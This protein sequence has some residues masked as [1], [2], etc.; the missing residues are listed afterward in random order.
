MLI[1]SALVFLFI[2]SETNLFDEHNDDCKDLDLCLILDKAHFEKNI[3]TNQVL[4]VSPDFIPLSS[5]KISQFSLTFSQTEFAIIS[6]IIPIPHNT[7][8]KN[9]SFLI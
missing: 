5:V 9:K 1:L 7:L 4:K 6:N 2:H 8:I 3:I